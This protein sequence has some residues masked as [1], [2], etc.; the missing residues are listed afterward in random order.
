[1]ADVVVTVGLE[2]EVYTA[3]LSAANEV[4]VPVSEFAG[5]LI[6]NY[7]EDNYGEV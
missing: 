7:L 6:A 1:M 3:L 4:G 2:P 5:A